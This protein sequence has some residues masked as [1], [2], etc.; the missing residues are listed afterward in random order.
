MVLVLLGFVNDLKIS[1]AT[2]A[3]SGLE[4]TIEEHFHPIPRSLAS[5][6]VSFGSHRY[7]RHESSHRSIY[8]SPIRPLKRCEGLGTIQLARRTVRIVDG[9]KSNHGYRLESIVPLCHTQRAYRNK[10]H[11]GSN[12][13]GLVGTCIYVGNLWRC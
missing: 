2:A 1:P 8:Q 12:G 13:K 3:H 4:L 7:S 10:H 11:Q 6:F 5:G 9:P